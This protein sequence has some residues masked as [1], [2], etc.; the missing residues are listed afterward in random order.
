MVRGVFF[1]IRNNY[2]PGHKENVYANLIC[3]A[4]KEK[5]LNFEKE[6]R[7]KIYSDKSGKPVG[8]YVPDYV[9]DDK[10]IV[11]VKASKLTTKQDE[12]Q[13]Y[14]YLRNSKYEI[15]LLV[16]FGTPELYIKRIVY[17]NSRKPFLKKSA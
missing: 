11:E 3:E 14:H 5:G 15:G 9:I 7:I 2:G 6:K 12:I 17:S 4:L 16:N 13:I 1:D 8:T 10:I